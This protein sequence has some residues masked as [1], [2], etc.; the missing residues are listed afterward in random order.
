MICEQLERRLLLSYAPLGSPVNVANLTVGTQIA[1]S[2]RTVAADNS[3]NYRVVWVDSVKG[4][5]TRLFDFDG[6]GLGPVKTVDAN[7]SDYQPT[8][9]MDDAGDFVVAWTSSN[10]VFAQRFAPDATPL[11]S[12]QGFGTV[13]VGNIVFGTASQP[14]VA[15]DALGNYALAYDESNPIVGVFGVVAT[16]NKP[17]GGSGTFS[18]LGPEIAANCDSPSVA[19]NAAGNFVVAYRTGTGSADNEI[20][21]Q[22]FNKVGAKTA[23]AQ[24][25]SSDLTDAQPS[26]AI[27]GSGNFD[28]AYTH[29]ISATVIDTG[30][31]YT[32]YLTD[33]RLRRFNPNGALRGSTTIVGGTGLETGSAY[34]PCAT[35]DP[36]GD[37]VVAY[38]LGGSFSDFDPGAGIPTALASAYDSAG[39]EAQTGL[40]LATPSA[41][42]NDFQPSIALS[43]NGNLAAAWGNYGTL[44]DGESFSSNGV[45]TQTFANS[46]FGYSLP[47]G[48]VIHLVGGVPKTYKVTISRDPSF[49]GSVSVSVDDVPPGVGVA[50]SPDTG[51]PSDS[52]V[53]TFTEASTIAAR[54]VNTRLRFV[55]GGL[56]LTPKIQIQ[57]TPSI[58][59]APNA[60]PL[61]IGDRIVIAGNG[62][63]SGSIV[64]FGS[65]GFNVPS[66]QATPIDISDPDPFLAGT[67]S[68]VVPKGAVNGYISILRPG[69]L[70]IVST[71]YFTIASSLVT[72]VSRTTVTAPYLQFGGTTIRIYGDGFKSGAKVQ[73]GG[74]GLSNPLLL[75]TPQAISSDGKII[76]VQ[77]GVFALTG[78]ITVIEPDGSSA[79]S[80]QSVTV[81][82]FPGT[83]GFGFTNNW[84]SGTNLTDLTNLFGYD[85]THDFIGAFGVGVY[86]SD[87]FAL[88]FMY[89]ARGSLDDG[90]CFGMT[91]GASRLY[92]LDASLSSFPPSSAT[93]SWQLSPG[94]PLYSYLHAQHIA[95]WSSQGLAQQV[96]DARLHASFNSTQV[97]NEIK[98]Y[99]D[100]GRATLVDISAFGKGHSVL[101]Y[102]AEP[103][104]GAGDYYIDVYDPNKPSPTNDA[105]SFANLSSSRI[106][107]RS[108]GTW[109]YTGNFAP[110]TDWSGPFQNMNFIPYGAIPVQPSLPNILTGLLVVYGGGTVSQVSDPSG[111][112]LL[113]LDGS[114][115]GNPATSLPNST[116]IKDD[117]SSGGPQVALGVNDITET[118]ISNGTPSGQVFLKD[119]FGVQLFNGIDPKGVKDTLNLLADQS[120]FNFMTSG[121]ARALDAELMTKMSTGLTRTATFDTTTFTNAGDTVAFDPARQNVM[122]THKGAAAM[123]SLTLAEPDSAGAME[124]FAGAVMLAAGDSAVFAPSNWSGLNG[125]TMAVTI[126]HGNGTKTHQSLKNKGGALNP[127][128]AEGASFSGPIATVIPAAA[129]PAGGFK[130]SIDWGDSSP[131]ATGSATANGS[132]GYVIAGAH[133]FKNSGIYEATYTLLAGGN[134]AGSGVLQIRVTEAVLGASAPA[135]SAATGKLFNG[136][137]ATIT[138]ANAAEAAADLTASINW[139]D[140]TASAGT[141]VRTGAGK[142]NIVGSHTYAKP[143]SFSVVTS[144]TDDSVDL[145]TAA[146]QI[147]AT[148][149]K[150]FNGAVGTVAIPAPGTPIGNYSGTIAWGDGSTSL[151]TFSLHG[152]VIV[153][154]GKHTYAKTGKYNVQLEL[155]GGLTAIAKG[156]AKV[157]GAAPLT[158][159][160]TIYNDLNKNGLR[161]VA[162]GG[163]AGW[164]AYVDLT[165]AGIYVAGDPIATTDAKG[166]YTLLITPSSGAKSLIIREVRQT[167]WQR[168]QPAGVYP[169]GFYTVTLPATLATSLDFGNV[170]APAATSS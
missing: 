134:M 63:L 7:T 24:V 39:N 30:F 129:A 166:N 42:D 76:T 120:S 18:S 128:V 52:R 99:L 101:A 81:S 37:F 49:S 108:D 138:D 119:G 60:D 169:L 72:G 100:A 154:S 74:A 104:N 155:K 26:A 153:F 157:S 123:F 35:I 34:A 131:L 69:A 164:Q 4:L 159:K 126:T 116:T 105:S 113:N 111:H 125:A 6:F 168:T 110:P 45:F 102:A 59:T 48:N 149:T 53:I 51:A 31:V 54:T 77:P 50:V 56:T 19:M 139:G 82:D 70:P 90:Q 112:R 86:V 162:E 3:G 160:G 97:Y 146:N 8:V 87:P 29:I 64:Q 22:A 92:S 79:V 33:V 170:L 107:L 67:L 163:L 10:Q 143:A 2:S 28:I 25:T 148:K 150:A 71:H 89:A 117:F 136:V 20:A 95:Q 152:D 132:G 66:E 135:I 98:G 9:A 46:V 147:D 58:I 91:L 156:I 167:G 44:T 12:A 16:L 40:Q 121:P 130:V 78:P 21:A 124:S 109:A 145:K 62:F 55:G 161:D 96:I 65:G 57:V 14:S 75:S 36:N 5:Q 17:T 1:G 114:L 27:D 144:V 73:F 140:G 142:F 103:G 141:V 23:S 115:N 38:T 41:S 43:P 15:I 93:D 165:N 85:A 68:V 61:V 13:R 88:A 11:G 84:G 106:H 94:D 83:H 122:V 80:P 32:Q 47:P 151:A 127:T 137:V 133:V 158:I 118:V